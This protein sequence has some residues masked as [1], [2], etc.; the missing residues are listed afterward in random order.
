MILGALFVGIAACTD[1]LYALLSGSLRG[2]LNRRTGLVTA[3]RWVSGGI[4]IGLGVAA[5]LSG[6]RPAK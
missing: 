2:L 1:S 4:Y 6:A 5:A 3:R